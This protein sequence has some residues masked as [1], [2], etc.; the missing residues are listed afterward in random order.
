[1]IN[2]VYGREKTH[3]AIGIAFITQVLLVL[4]ILLVK[5]LPPA[6]FFKYE[7]AWQDIFQMGLRITFASWVSFL[8]CQ[9]VDAYVFSTLKKRFESKIILRSVT[10]DILDL[11]LDSIIFIIVAFYGRMPLSMLII[12]Q[13]VTKNLIGI[14]DTPWFLWYKRIITR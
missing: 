1:M 7:E 9:N 13:I 3:L 8:I 12:G 11:T 2:E 10:S 4:F 5:K 14:I 6:P